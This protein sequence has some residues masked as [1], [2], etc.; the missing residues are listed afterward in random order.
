MRPVVFEALALIALSLP[1]FMGDVMNGGC[2]AVNR[3]AESVLMSPTL[4]YTGPRA[5]L[6]YGTMVGRVKL[7]YRRCLE[8]V[9]TFAPG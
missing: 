8:I 6:A 4:I 7:F 9:L 2:P 3:T 1:S 5:L